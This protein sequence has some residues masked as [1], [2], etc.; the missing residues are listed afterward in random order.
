MTESDR[1]LAADINRRIFSEPDIITLMCWSAEGAR[2]EL[3]ANRIRIP[4]KGWPKV[5]DDDLTCRRAL[6]ILIRV[7]ALEFWLESDAPEAKQSAAT[8]AYHLGQLVFAARLGPIADD[9]AIG[10]KCKRGGADSHGTLAQRKAEYRPL[11]TRFGTLTKTHSKRSAYEIIGRENGL[12]A[13]A[14]RY[15]ISIV[16]S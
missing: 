5:S 12:A 9:L 16:T 4:K 10:R 15:R 3:R 14:V 7:R 13:G 2:R 1:K 8:E 11:W 6:R